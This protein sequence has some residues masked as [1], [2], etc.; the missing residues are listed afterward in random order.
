MVNAVGT[1]YQAYASAQPSFAT[2]AETRANTE[3][4]QPRQAP[5]ADSQRAD[6]K[7]LASREDDS[8]KTQERSSRDESSSAANDDS[9][10]RGAVLDVSV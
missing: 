2:G 8:K 10:R 3:Q 1:G 4:V 9:S 5:A 6:Q 7:S